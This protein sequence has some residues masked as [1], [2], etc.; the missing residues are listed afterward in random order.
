M[1]HDAFFQDLLAAV[2][3][4]LAAPQTRYVAKTLQRLT[5]GGMSE[6]DAKERIAAC[7][8]EETDAMYRRKKGFDEKSYQE[9]LDA[10][11]ADEKFEDGEDEEE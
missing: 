1:D 7:L 10:I 8:G 5:A 4:Q 3:Q 9:K 11:R 2:E 6:Q